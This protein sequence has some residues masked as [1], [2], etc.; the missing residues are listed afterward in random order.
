[1]EELTVIIPVHEYNENVS[2]YLQLAIDSVKEQ[3]EQPQTIIIVGPKIVVDSILK[4][5]PKESFKFVI[6]DGETDYCSQVNLGVTNCKT[7]YFSILEYDDTYNK[8]WFKN[9]KSYIKVKPEYSIFLPI[10]KFV[11]EDGKEIGTSNE[12]C[13]AMAFANELGV[14]D[15]DILESYYDFSVTGGVFRTDDFIESGLLKPSIK[16]SFWYEYLLRTVNEGIKVFVIPKN[17]YNHT[18]NR[19]GS[20]MDSIVGMTG[21]ERNFWMKL[22]KK[23]YFFKKERVSNAKYVA[24]KE[25]EDI[26]EL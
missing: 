16:L 22:A 21:K 25:I 13:W 10:N 8:I 3:T 15:A 12:I 7:K 18:V 6:N 23:E 2:K 4:D 11:E 20:L 17:G 24:E 14:I 5:S 1:M 26:E 19:K 9:V